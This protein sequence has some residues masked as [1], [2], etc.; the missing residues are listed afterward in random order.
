MPKRVY[1]WRG[2]ASIENFILYYLKVYSALRCTLTLTVI[3][4]FTLYPLSQRSSYILSSLQGFR[5]RSKNCYS[6]AIRR[7]Q[8]ALQYQY[9]SRKLKKREM[10]SVSI[11]TA[12]VC[13]FIPLTVVTYFTLFFQLWITR[14][15]IATREHNVN[16]STFMNKMVQV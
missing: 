16:Y 2:G 5:G 6:I 14:I 7:V 1:K 3:C 9:I 4:T 11:S 8:K 13:L 12:H 10:R 15:N